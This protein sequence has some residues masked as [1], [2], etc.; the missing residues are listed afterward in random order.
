VADWKSAGQSR[1]PG[2]GGLVLSAIC[3]QRVFATPDEFFHD[4]PWLLG[5]CQ[6][7]IQTCGRAH[8]PRL[9]RHWSLTSDVFCAQVCAEYE[10]SDV[11]GLREPHRRSLYAYS[12]YCTTTSEAARQYPVEYTLFFNQATNLIFALANLNCK[13]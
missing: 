3:A 7:M 12:A 13:K 8:N 10:C 6:G 9:P 4:F 11:Q 5:K 2:K 1:L